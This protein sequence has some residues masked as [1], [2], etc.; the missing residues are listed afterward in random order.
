MKQE[1]SAIPIA[2]PLVGGIDHVWAG[3]IFPYIHISEWIDI[4]MIVTYISNRFHKHPEA[5]EVW[6]ST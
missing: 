5:N 4:R 2:Q 6:T 1:T 3:I